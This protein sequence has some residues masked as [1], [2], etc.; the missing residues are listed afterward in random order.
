MTFAPARVLRA[1][2]DPLS[3]GRSHIHFTWCTG[4]RVQMENLK[5]LRETLLNYY[6]ITIDMKK[7]YTRVFLDLASPL[8]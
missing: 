7:E 3:Q 1:R 4:T 8:H 6:R 2:A 5:L